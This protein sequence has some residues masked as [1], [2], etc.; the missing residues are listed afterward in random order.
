MDTFT[1]EPANEEVFA[2]QRWDVFDVDWQASGAPRDHVC[3]AVVVVNPQPRTNDC[4]GCV[5]SWD[6]EPSLRE[7]DCD[8]VPAGELLRVTAIGIGDVSTDLTGVDPHPGDSLGA[9]VQIDG[10]DWLPQGWAYAEDL[11][12]GGEGGDWDGETVFTLWPDFAWPL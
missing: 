3:G 5:A 11:D 8:G 4:P 12:H 9:W 10:G 7:T 2:L 6:A 1:I